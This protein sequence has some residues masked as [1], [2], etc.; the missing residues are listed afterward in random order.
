MDVGTTSRKRLTPHQ[1]LRLFESHGGKCALCG[2]PIQA[3]T[4]WIV[5]HLRALGLGGTNDGDNLA[6]VHLDCANAKTAQ[7]DM[8]RIAKAKRQKLRHLGIEK[9]GPKLRSRGFA[10]VERKRAIDKDALP[11]LPRKELFK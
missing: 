4:K 3:G 5:E 10:R 9:S 11:A 1:R 8:P 6:P 2:L 7:E